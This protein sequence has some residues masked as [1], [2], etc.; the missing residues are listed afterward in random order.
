MIMSE[1]VTMA[2][3]KTIEHFLTHIS[4][5]FRQI[6]NTDIIQLWIIDSMTCRA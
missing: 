2:S 1:F 5:A 3:Y 4:K 6:F